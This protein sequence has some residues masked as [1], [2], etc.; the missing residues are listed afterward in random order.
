MKLGKLLKNFDDYRN[1][2]IKEVG[3]AKGVNVLRGKCRKSD[4]PIGFVKAYK[5]H[6]VLYITC[7]FERGKEFFTNIYIRAKKE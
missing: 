4:L 5:N 2:M 1:L 3:A 6:K 7:P